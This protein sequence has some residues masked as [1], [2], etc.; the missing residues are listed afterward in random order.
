MLN[1]TDCK[2]KEKL[3]T[4]IDPSPIVE[5]NPTKKSIA[6][7]LVESAKVLGSDSQ[8]ISLILLKLKNGVGVGKNRNRQ[9]PNNWIN[10]WKNAPQ[11]TPIAKP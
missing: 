5:A 9:T 7:L 11:T 2:L 4:E 10:I 6:K 3:K 1:G 8:T